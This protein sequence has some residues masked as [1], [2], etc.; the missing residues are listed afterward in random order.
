MFNV[1]LLSLA[2]FIVD[3]DIKKFQEI[4]A[5]CKDNS[6]DLVVVGPENPLASGIADHLKKHGELQNANFLLTSC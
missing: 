6:I 3:L 5:W 1:I 4:S 2:F